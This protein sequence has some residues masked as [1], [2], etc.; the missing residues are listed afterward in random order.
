[1]SDQLRVSDQHL[2]TVVRRARQTDLEGLVACSNALAEDAG[3][4]DPSIHVGRPRDFG[5]ARFAAAMDD[6]SRLLLVADRGEQVVGHLMGTL[7]EGTAMRPVEVATLV[8]MYVQPSH[9]RDGLGARLVGQFS[10]WAKESGAAPAEVTAHSGDA[11]AI[12]LYER[13]GFASQPV[14]LRAPL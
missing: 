13:N 6:P 8:S 3:T 5:P 2:E 7:T 11:E 4:R 9:R 12:R 10:A 14:T 1:M